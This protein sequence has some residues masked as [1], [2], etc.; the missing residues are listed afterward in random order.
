M[1]LSLRRMLAVL[2]LQR[3]SQPQ[4]SRPLNVQKLIVRSHIKGKA[5]HK[6]ISDGKSIYAASD[7]CTDK[8]RS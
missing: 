5:S 1:I 2:A 3:E 4:L 8:L 7:Q 6:I